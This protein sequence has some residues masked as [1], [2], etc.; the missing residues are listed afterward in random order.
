MQPLTAASYVSPVLTVPKD[1]DFFN[2]PG[3]LLMTVAEGRKE[4]INLIRSRLA[5]WLS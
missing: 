5:A 1:T 4:R 3:C 2:V